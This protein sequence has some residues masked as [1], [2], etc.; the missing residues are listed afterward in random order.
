MVD[1][2]LWLV[3]NVFLPLVGQVSR[4]ALMKVIGQGATDKLTLA[5]SS[6]VSF[7]ILLMNASMILSFGTVHSCLGSRQLH[8]RTFACRYLAR[9]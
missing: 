9:D 6:A 7:A 5:S 2:A 8:F 4:V 3:S 1:I